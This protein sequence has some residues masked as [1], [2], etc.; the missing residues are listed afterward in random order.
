MTDKDRAIEAL[1]PRG[2]GHQFVF[3]GDSCSGVP[4][5]L[6]E[7]KL[8]KVNAVV[9]R[10]R[11]APDFAV[12]PGDEVI[13]LIPDEAELRRQWH[14]FFDVEMAWAR[15]A[16]L[17][18]YHATGNH[19]TYDPMSER[20]FADVMAHLPRNGPLGQD[21]LSY[22]VR[23][24]DLLLVFVHTLSTALGGEGHI[25]TEW[26]RATLR[27][28][29]DARW[30]FVVGH[31]PAFP[32]NGYVGTY[33]RTIGDE[34]VPAFWSILVEAGV[35]AYL[36]SH[37]L[38]FDVQCH[39]GVLQITSA[40]AGTAHRMPEDVEYLHCVQM[41]ID[42]DGL[43]YQV[44]DE[45]GTLREALHWPPPAPP[46]HRALDT[47]RNTVDGAHLGTGPM[48]FGL[49]GRAAASG[50]RQ[51]LC[52]AVTDS[53]AVPFWL[54]LV[55]RKLQL[56]AILQPVAGRSPHQWL[57]PCFAPGDAFD[58]DVLIHPGMGP[59][60]L[61]WRGRGADRWTG[62]DGA[63]PW[64]AE[65]LTWPDTLWVGACGA[66]ERAIAYAGA[67][68]KVRLGHGAGGERRHTQ[69]EGAANR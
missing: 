36:C 43:R 27:D 68:L 41:A 29:A 65:R 10:L 14:H 51:T 1:T 45:D 52:A 30:K 7:Q 5:H 11:P 61:L 16:D 67:D 20:V 64:G 9:R 54:G 25:E 38:A 21:G 66:G 39:A 19:T 26:L 62:F 6:H 58:L 35:S 3:Y 32:V 24:G 12:F 17:R 31:H 13:G 15:A 59:G 23:E 47:G 8:G 40:G 69:Q 44:L 60:G 55:G 2:A 48:T 57:G 33:Q 28:H 56:T 34:Y 63:S 46:Q 42:T 18:I 37:I 50:P 53:G 49:S 4:G 22:Y